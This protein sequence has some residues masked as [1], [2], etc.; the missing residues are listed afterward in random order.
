M[1]FPKLHQKKALNNA[2]LEVIMTQRLKNMLEVVL[3]DGSKRSF[4][5]GTTPLNVAQE[6]SPS[7]AKRVVVA[8]V[9]GQ[10]WDLNRPM[11]DA[12]G[13]IELFDL[14]TP[15]GLDVLRHDTAH[16]LAAAIKDLFPQAQITIGPSI[17]NG[18]YYD[19]YRRD[20]ITPGVTVEASFTPD[21]LQ[22]LEKRMHELVDEKLPFVRQE[23]ARDEAIA[24]FKS[25]GEHFKVE[26]IES[27]PAGEIVSVYT[28]GKLTDLCRGPHMPTTEKI[29]HAFKLTHLAGAYWRG[30]ARNPMLQRIYGT[31][32]PSQKELDHYLL[33]QEEAKKRDHRKLGAE[34]GWF[35]L[36]EEAPGSVFWHPKGWFVYRS[37]ENYIRHKISRKGYV[38]VRTPSLVGRHLWEA[39]GHWEQY[40]ENMVTA[41]CDDRT[42]AVKPMNCPCHVQIF[43]QGL[44]SYRDLPLR[45]AEFGS[46]HRYEPSGAL[47]GIMRLRSFIQDDAHIFCTPG[48]ILGEIQD[49]CVLL[50]E[51]YSELGFTDVRIKLATRPE[52]RAG[53]DKAWDEAE[54][55]LIKASEFSGLSYELNPGEG[56]FYGPKLEFV[57]RDALGRDWQCGTL[58]VDYVL[59]ER[60]GASYIGEDGQKHHPIMLHRAILGSLE[61]FIGVFMEHTAG[62]M[63]LW[64]APIQAVIVP[65]SEKHQAYA[66]Q[67]HKRMEEAGLRIEVDKGND[68]MNYK[69]RQAVTQKVPYVIILGDKEMDTQT[70]SVRQR[71]GDQQNGL[72]VGG[73]IEVLVKESQ[74]PYV[75]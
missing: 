30:D 34:L 37:L 25:Q 45:M 32:W 5:I 16:I 61:R 49:F 57:L 68:T 41:E 18:F 74:P 38:E 14:T 8:S 12:G 26:L 53:D 28:V 42:Y 20:E 44:K 1:I 73:W 51:V 43:N 9:N 31:V 6:L 7:L 27:I 70:L 59:P 52:K 2:M 13:T 11:P 65:I 23:W 46:C 4:S 48:Q 72:D 50:K 17:D 36:Q 35:H 33:M 67:L 62:H 69:I 66:D 19:V 24:F 60:L 54:D 39:S 63:P 58:Q 56:A 22:A 47:H 3:K 71:Q 15:D 21:D 40:R 10:P 29:G 64:L 55:A 75:K